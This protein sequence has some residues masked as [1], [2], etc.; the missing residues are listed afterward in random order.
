MKNTL[1]ARLGLLVVA[2]LF[3][4]VI[5]LSNNLFRGVKLDLTENSIYTLS[6]GTRG[7]LSQL[8]EPVN[9]TLYFSFKVSEDYQA[10]RG[11]A[12]RV[13][14][15]LAEFAQAAGGK[16][17]VSVVDP[18]PF[19]EQEDVAAGFGLTGAPV[20]NV[21]TKLYFGIAG[22]NAIGDNMAL[23]FLQQEKEAFLEYDI[24]KLIYQLAHPDKTTVGLITGLGVMGGKV[25]QPG[26]PASP[27]WVFFQELQ[28]FF[29]IRNLGM[30]VAAIPDGID[31]LMIVHPK[32]LSDST[33]YAIDQFVLRGGRAAIFVDPM[34]DRD[35]GDQIGGTEFLSSS[36]PQL[37]SAWGI[38]NPETLFVAD[39]A[40]A[41]QVQLDYNSP[42]VTNLS[43]G[44]FK[45]THLNQSDVVTQGLETINMSS[46]GYFL[47]LSDDPGW[48]SNG[49]DSVT[50][51]VGTEITPLIVS[52]T[53]AAPMAS[54]RL[55]YIP[56]PSVLFEAF[57][58]TGA[59]YIIAARISG[60]AKTAFPD[61][62]PVDSQQ[63]AAAHLSVS[64]SDINVIVVADT[65]VLSDRLWVRVQDFLGQQ[66][67]EPWASNGDFG[68][69]LLDSLSGS[70]DL[71]SIR[72]R[73][74]FARPFE[75]ID[76]LRREA[77]STFREQEQALKAR[78]AETE[79]QLAAL[80]QSNSDDGTMA[81]SAEQSDLLL[82][83]QN[84][85]FD[86]RKQLR[87]VR[88]QLDQDI[89]SLGARIKLINIILIPLLVLLFA[90]L[91]MVRRGRSRA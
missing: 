68:V 24:A 27:P 85:Q 60:A 23:P 46:V 22:S 57:L 3:L 21:G 49:L 38:E 61:G 9:L 44:R 5:M 72:S 33:Q 40:N 53:Q 84:E 54:T 12:V 7:V 15:L 1:S 18:E 35:V 64:A 39:E 62:P 89:E 66:V 13:E 65:D 48:V 79:S 28:S 52:S 75:K 71:I 78:L 77:E 55:G 6:D 81:L 32:E 70:N 20:D 80:Q 42:P 37:F 26:R 17:T 76:D 8:E 63:D 83:F 88:H 73:G 50:T 87:D 16:V 74:V 67:V 34:A 14:E 90:G 59:E 30:G 43:I 31:L 19:S 69:N 10:L 58:P 45:S 91:Q 56:D 51:K 82:K 11:Y 41:M 47:P 36:L 2:F 86:I 25:T 29:D 4:G